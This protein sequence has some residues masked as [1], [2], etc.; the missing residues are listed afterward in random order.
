MTLEV[1]RRTLKQGLKKLRSLV[2]IKIE[3]AEDHG[4]EE[5]DLRPL[6]IV[7]EYYGEEI[8]TVEEAREF[9]ES[10]LERM[11][12]VELEEVPKVV[13][14]AFDVIEG[15]KHEFEPEEFMYQGCELDRLDG[16]K[17]DIMTDDARDGAAYVGEPPED[18]EE[19]LWVGRVVSTIS[20]L[21]PECAEAGLIKR[22]SDVKGFDVRVGRF[23]LLNYVTA[24]AF[25]AAG[26]TV[27]TSWP[28]SPA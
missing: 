3:L 6:P 4:T 27:E 14:S 22:C 5:V 28:P 20:R 16:L 9:Y 10:E 21:L 25:D 18:V 17:L 8:R 13:F 23:T 12:R 24:V 19:G 26:A 11:H 2:R 15:V 1:R 7:K